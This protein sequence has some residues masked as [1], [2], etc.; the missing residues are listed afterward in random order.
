MSEKIISAL[1][2]HFKTHRLIFWYDNEGKLFDIF[3]DY[4]YFGVEK[5]ILEN[6]EFEV[7]YQ[8][9][10]VKP[11]DKFLIYSIKAKPAPEEN[12]LLDLNL[13]NLV[14]ATDEV[15]LY[16][17]ELNLPSVFKPIIKEHLKFFY[18]NERLIP[19]KNML[20]PDETVQSF[21]Y[22]MLTVLCSDTKSGKSKR[23]NLNEITIK[24]FEDHFN[25]NEKKEY[26]ME[27]EKYNLISFFWEEAN[28]E[29]MYTSSNPDLQGLVLH[30][31]RLAFECDSNKKMNPEN[32]YS[33]GFIDYWR[34]NLKHSDSFK[35]II[36]T[37][38]NELNI[39]HEIDNINLNTLMDSDIFKK[40]DKN[41][42][43]YLT[44]H[45]VS[46]SI[47]IK[48]AL[49]IIEKRKDKYWYKN[50]IEGKITAFYQCLYFYFIFK[51]LMLENK[52][53][54]T[55]QLEGWRL[56]T[57][58]LYKI[59]Q[60]YLNF[61][62]HYH[63]TGTETNFAL[64]LDKIEKEYVNNYL[65]KLSEKWQNSFSIKSIISN[66]YY[67]KQNNFFTKIIKRYLTT[68]KIVFVIIS[69]GLRYDNGM[70]LAVNLETMNRFIVKTTPMVASIPS[71]TQLGMAA[72][73][74]QKGI[75]LNTKTAQVTINGRSTSGLDNRD[76]ILQEQVQ[77]EFS[78]KKA[79][80]FEA[81]YFSELSYKEQEEL[82][83]GF[84][85]IYLY[86]NHIDSIG[87]NGKTEKRLPVAVKEEI[88]FLSNLCRKITNLNRTHIVITADHG[89]L[90]QYKKVEG[91]DFIN[92]KN[93]NPDS[94]ID[95][96]FVIGKNL[97][98]T[99]GTINISGKELNLNEDINILIPKGLY[100][101]R[102]QGGGTQYVHGGIT[103]QEL[104]IPVIQ[105]TKTRVDDIRL[106]NIEVLNP[107]ETIT[108]GQISIK[109]YQLEPISN[110]VNERIIISRFEA[111]NGD[112]ISSE[113]ELLFNSNDP[114]N[115][116]RSKVQSFIFNKR[117]EKQNNKVVKLKLYEK[118]SSDILVHYREYAFRFRKVITSD[119]EF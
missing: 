92:L 1:N 46:D 109:F 57:E 14:F 89:F 118:K 21:R 6:N 49:S 56:Y 27:I 32:Q 74:P 97:K 48:E 38:E 84:D 33:F 11:E 71:Y 58:K 80:A 100:R 47:N 108:T 78:N 81:R 88:D 96:R 115:Q 107:A 93:I 13:A 69:D 82:I 76:I 51:Q 10:K 102:K 12:W 114:N 117:A 3:N 20:N 103:L 68:N 65:L 24:L 7:K 104:C 34:N 52:I 5:I 110:K 55:D 64:L 22:A 50:D 105:I 54:F 85:L 112:I 95:R 36:D 73:L 77:S 83:K 4:F 25:K 113:H 17:Q 8:V 2:N 30:I 42:L 91:S 9:L 61:L 23:K 101:I 39:Q 86:S 53:D 35:S 16:L 45:S 60:V 75:Q 72:L 90:F 87:D 19:L 106:V 119:F 59:D 37:V 70:E 26:W 41:I 94:Y 44:D 29:Y 63:K 111:E 18:N 62:Y 28:K 79:K 43:S 98:A 31:F 67:Y 40:V 116:N 66:S 99:E 15:A